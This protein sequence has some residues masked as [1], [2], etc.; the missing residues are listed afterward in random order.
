VHNILAKLSVH[1]RAEAVSLLRQ[2]VVRGFGERGEERPRPVAALAP[3]VPTRRP[4][5]AG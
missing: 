1:R 5:R 3:A 4:G 2:A